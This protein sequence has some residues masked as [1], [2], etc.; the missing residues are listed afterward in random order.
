MFDVLL[1][2]HEHPTSN[3]EHPTSNAKAPSPL[4]LS[5]EYRGEG[6]GAAAA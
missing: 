4:A 5:P 3:I 2:S 6:E 1:P